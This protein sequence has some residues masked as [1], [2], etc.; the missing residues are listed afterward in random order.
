VQ[1]PDGSVFVVYYAEDAAGV[2]HILGSRFRL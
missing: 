1:D 2:T